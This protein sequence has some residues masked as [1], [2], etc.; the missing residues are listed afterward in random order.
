MIG[1]RIRSEVGFLF[2]F[3]FLLSLGLFPAN[4]A[5][6]QKRIM[7]DPMRVESGGGARERGRWNVE[8]NLSLSAR[9]DD[10]FFQ[11]D[12]NEHSVYTYIAQPGIEVDYETAKSMIRLLY[13]LNFHEYQD[14][15]DG[16]DGTADN[17]DFIGHSLGLNL[18][19]SPTPKLTFGISDTLDVTREQGKDDPFA[20]ETGRDR[21]FINRFTP[22]MFY[23]FNNRFSSSL[24]YS[25]LLLDYKAENEKDSVENRGTWGGFYDLSPNTTV[26]L[27]YQYWERDYDSVENQYSA[28]QGELTFNTRGKFLEL[29]AGAGYQTRDFDAADRSSED[30]LTYRMAFTGRTADT[31]MGPRSFLTLGFGQNFTNSGLRNDFSET[32]QFEASAGH[33]FRDRLLFEIAGA[34]LNADYPQQTVILADGESLDREDDRYRFNASVAYQVQRWLDFVLTGG[35]EK[36]DSNLPGF[37]FDSSYVQLTLNTSYD[38]GRR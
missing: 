37:D 8:T 34:Y 6:A 7:I 28:N 29:E 22:S 1:K 15:D 17:N 21:Y 3:V 36:R 35:Y 20:N 24:A 16:P 30:G 19:T 14:Q 25:N 2:F 27:N 11:D 26:G 5:M 4:E 9:Y 32:L 12:Q 13:S 23:R 10:N 33:V 38:L 31:P 18:R